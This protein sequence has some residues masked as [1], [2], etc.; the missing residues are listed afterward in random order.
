MSPSSARKHDRREL[1]VAVR[2][3]VQE[4]LGLMGQHALGLDVA[5]RGPVDRRNMDD[6]DSQ[7]A[8]RRQAQFNDEQQPVTSTQ[9]A[10]GALDD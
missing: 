8:L 10:Q 9:R 5:V 4:V 3:A 6:H 1:R 7:C 2:Y